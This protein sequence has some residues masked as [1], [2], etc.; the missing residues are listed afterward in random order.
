MNL[1]SYLQVYRLLFGTDIDEHM[2]TI[3]KIRHKR[4]ATVPVP[5]GE[6][7]PLFFSPDLITGKG[8]PPKHPHHFPKLTDLFKD[9][10]EHVKYLDRYG[11]FFFGEDW[12]Q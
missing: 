10:A 6:G 2:D 11:S 7:A 8:F 3:R 9:D 4:S 12:V 1:T 5:G